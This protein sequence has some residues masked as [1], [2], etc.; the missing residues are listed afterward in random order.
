MPPGL[1]QQQGQGIPLGQLL[2]NADVIQK[3]LAQSQPA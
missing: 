2:P 1:G 3:M